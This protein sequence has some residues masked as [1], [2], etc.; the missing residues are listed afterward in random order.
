MGALERED[1]VLRIARRDEALP[2]CVSPG[3]RSGTVNEADQ[4]RSPWRRRG[5]NVEVVER[6]VV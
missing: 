5:Q 3:T 6:R 4:G 1:V 2:E